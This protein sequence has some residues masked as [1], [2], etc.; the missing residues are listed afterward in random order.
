MAN[1]NGI[2]NMAWLDSD[3]ALFN[4]ILPKRAML[5]NTKYEDYDPMVLQKIIAMYVNGGQLDA[6]Q[7]MQQ[8]QA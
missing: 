2:K 4:K 5:R 7:K 3:N 8:S 6:D 1:N